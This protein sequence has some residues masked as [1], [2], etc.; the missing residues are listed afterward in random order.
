MFHKVGS[1][2]IQINVH[3]NDDT[4]QDVIQFNQEQLDQNKD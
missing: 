3:Q 4:I 2:Q 1:E